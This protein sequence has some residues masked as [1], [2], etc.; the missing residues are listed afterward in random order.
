MSEQPFASAR[1]ESDRYTIEGG[2]PWTF[3]RTFR[4]HDAAGALVL[5]AEHPLF[6]KEREIVLYADEEMLQPLLAVEERLPRPGLVRVLDIFDAHSYRRLGAI[7]G[8]LFHSVTGHHDVL[9]GEDRVAGK[10]VR[11][12]RGLF[13]LL[14]PSRA[15]DLELGG[16]LVARFFRR[17][18]GLRAR[19]EVQVSRADPGIDPRFAIA[20]TLAM[21]VGRYR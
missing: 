2:F 5:R 20:C 7:R 13:G 21:H 18:R 19:Y 12:N 10:I 15:F 1:I 14:G 8:R 3:E 17:G 6:Q 11:A 16:V 9:D 4:V